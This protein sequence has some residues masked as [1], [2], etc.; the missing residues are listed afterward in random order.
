MLK[1]D[2]YDYCSV[3]I[4]VKGKMSTTGTDN[5]KRRNK[6]LTFRNYAPFRP[7]ISNINCTFIDNAEDLDICMLMYN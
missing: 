7:C 5:T 3:L 4:V 1:S 2:L 6:K